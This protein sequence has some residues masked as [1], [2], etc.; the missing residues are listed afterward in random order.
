VILV[1][2]GQTDW[3][4]EGIF[5]GR[6]DVKLNDTNHIKSVDQIIENNRSPENPLG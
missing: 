3:N 5:R 4:R 6:I 2:H 1:R